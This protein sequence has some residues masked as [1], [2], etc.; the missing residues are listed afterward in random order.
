MLVAS[1][2]SLPARA[3]AHERAVP[4]AVKRVAGARV[5]ARDLAVRGF[6][7]ADLAVVA[8]CE[9]VAAADVSEVLEDVERPSTCE[10]LNC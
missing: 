2:R 10:E 9:H 6:M 8:R 5:V 7:R 4:V 1:L 3:A